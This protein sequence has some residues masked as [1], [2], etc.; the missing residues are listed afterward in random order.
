VIVL[1]ARPQDNE[2]L[3]EFMMTEFFGKNY[4]NSQ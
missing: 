2:G 1:S 3:E 4:K